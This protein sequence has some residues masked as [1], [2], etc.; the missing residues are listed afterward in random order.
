MTV[1]PS[2]IFAATSN[3]TTITKYSLL[4]MCNMTVTNHDNSHDPNNLKRERGKSFDVHRPSTKFF[5]L[6]II[7]TTL[8]G[9]VQHEQP[10][11]CFQ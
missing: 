3:R 6:A 5:F 4:C 7:L 2:S 10:S 11:Q 1:V 8:I 9:L